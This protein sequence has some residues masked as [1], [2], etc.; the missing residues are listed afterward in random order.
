MSVGRSSSSHAHLQTFHNLC[1]LLCIWYCLVV[2]S[3]YMEL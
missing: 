2:I 3:V 1:R